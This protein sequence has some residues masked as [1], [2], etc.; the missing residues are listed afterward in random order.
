VLTGLDLRIDD[1][2]RIG[3]LGA[4]GNG[5]STLAKLLAGRLAATGGRMRRLHRLDVAYFAQHQLD[6]LNPQQSAY[7]HVRLLMPDATEAQVRARTGAMGFARAKMDTPA[8]DLSGGEKARLLLGLVTFTGPNM[9]ILDEPTNH[10]DID[11]REALV[12]ALAA[13]SGAV[14]LISHDPHLTE[15]SVDRLWLVANG[16]ARPFDGDLGDYRAM[17]LE[18]R[19]GDAGQEGRGG[20]SP[21]QERRREAAR[22]REEVAPLRKQVKAVEVAIERLQQEIA[23]LD[24]KLAD[25]AL[26][27][28]PAK[29]AALSKARADAVKAMGETEERWLTLSAE[30]EA[31]MAAE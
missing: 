22:R 10:L 7:D 2:D 29:A 1:D 21:A 31:A 24:G 16:T 17:V 8:K 20:P 26:Y 11:S 14:I 18:Q 23:R 15:A 19:R 5:K 12:Q 25:A 4:N 28:D 30:L 27:A 6:E 3:L 9:L 13:Y